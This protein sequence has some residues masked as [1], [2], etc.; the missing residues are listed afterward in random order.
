[1][2]AIRRSAGVVLMKIEMVDIGKIK[3][4]ENNTKVHP[5]SQIKMIAESIDKFKF[6]QP[7]VVDENFV[8]IKGHGRLYAAQELGL[9]KVPTIIRTDL[10]EAQK[11]ASRIADNKSNESEWDFLKLDVELE[12]L[13][14]MD[15]NY[16]FGFE[17]EN[18][19][20]IEITDNPQKINI[21]PYEKIH[22]LLSFHPAI[23]NNIKNKIE[24]IKKIKGINYEQSAN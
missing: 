24:N 8:I 7:I 13:K 9:K 2:E 21:N 1:M 23:W 3:P 14:D 19:I 5:D 20:S 4:Y 6:D 11:K 15:F 16:E 18:D 10:T 17:S 12:E 22:I